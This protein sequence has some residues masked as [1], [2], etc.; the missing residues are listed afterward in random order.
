MKNR[1]F[2]LLEVVLYLA[3]FSMLMT[4]ALQTVY[5]VLETT[6]S[7]QTDIAILTERTFL[8]QKFSWALL[9]ATSVTLVSSTTVSMARPDLG[10]DSP[11][12]F[13]VSNGSWFLKRGTADPTKIS[14]RELVV[15]DAAVTLVSIGGG[16]TL[17]LRIQYR[18]SGEPFVFQSI[19]PYE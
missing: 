13:S 2:T 17:S 15:S 4:G 12:T 7:N 10:S 16:T 1:G 9:Q 8:N 3:L 14:T 18:L 19:I 5:V 11:L 6:K